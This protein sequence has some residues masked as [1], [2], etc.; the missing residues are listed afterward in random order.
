MQLDQKLKEEQELQKAFEE[1]KPLV[2]VAEAAQGITY[3]EPVQRSWRAPR[4][5]EV[6]RR[7]LVCAR[8]RALNLS[9]SFFFSSP[10]AQALRSEQVDKIRNTYHILVSG[11]DVP[12]PVTRFCD[13]KIPSAIVDVLA[14]SGIMRPTPIQMQG[15]PAILAGRDVIGVAF[16]GSGKTLVFVLPMILFALEAEL[17]LPLTDGEGPVGVVVCPSRELARQTFDLCQKLSGAL[18]ADR[19]ARWPALRG[20]L[21]IGGVSKGEQM[22]QMRGGCHYVV[23]TPGRL[24]DMLN[25][26]KLT[27]NNCTYLCLDEADRLV[28]MGFEEDIRN[29]MNHFRRQRQTLLFSATM[30]PKIQQFARSA[31]VAPVEVNVGRAGAAN[32]DVIQEVDY[33]KQ[34]AKIVYLLEVLQKTPPPVLI[35]CENKADVD[36][37]HEYLLLKGVEATSVH[38]GRSQEERETAIRE[39]KAGERDVLIATDVASKGLDFP[40]IVRAAAAA[41]AR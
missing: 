29:T 15:L 20:S 40:D 41:A 9:N 10:V 24:N 13:L 8:A 27:L 23:A 1:F 7:E 11:D 22:M 30:P 26:R 21:M 33:V 18:A 25:S 12:N 37:I 16:T 19:G 3:S 5:V 32:L 6:R 17:R 14:S 39:F 34:E 2:S 36:D 31:L 28:D 38:G 4:F 35:F